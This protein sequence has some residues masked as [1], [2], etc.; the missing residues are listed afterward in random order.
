M[1]RRDSWRKVLDFEVQ[2]WS[3]LSWERLIADLKDSQQYE[4]EVEGRRYQVEA[5]LLE[6]T[7]EYV[8]VLVAVDDGTLPASLRPLTESI[9]R[10]KGE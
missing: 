6:N 8:H 3:A 2:R 7:D 1:S 5:E 10:R 4:V 9:V